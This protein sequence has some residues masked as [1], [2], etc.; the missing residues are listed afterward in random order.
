MRWRRDSAGAAQSL[1]AR[2]VEVS[3]FRV[4]YDLDAPGARSQT[5][6]KTPRADSIKQFTLQ[7]DSLVKE[8]FQQQM[9][10]AP[11]EMKLAAAEVRDVVVG[12]RGDFHTTMKKSKGIDPKAKILPSDDEEIQ[13]D[14]SCLK[15][16]NSLKKKVKRAER[17][18]KRRPSPTSPS[19]TSPTR[20]TRH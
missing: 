1:Q 3:G 15:F 11:S 4:P 13:N 16:F 18:P 19:P 12:N 14:R 10:G 17:T 5:P 7:N 6:K 8:F 9:W 20:R 2:L